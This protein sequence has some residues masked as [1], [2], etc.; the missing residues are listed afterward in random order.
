M[1]GLSADTHFPDLGREDRSWK[2]EITQREV[3]NKYGK[4]MQDIDGKCGMDR[5]SHPCGNWDEWNRRSAF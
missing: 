5:P 2:E 4:L 3:C 1:Q